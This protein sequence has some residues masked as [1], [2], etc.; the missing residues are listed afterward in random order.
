MFNKVSVF[1]QACGLIE[2]SLK[3]IKPFCNMHERV[4]EH[5]TWVLIA[6]LNIC[7]KSPCIFSFVLFH[8][9]IHSALSIYCC[10]HEQHH[11]EHHHDEH[12]HDEHHH[13]EPHHDEHHYDDHHYHNH[14][15]DK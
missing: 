5:I 10:A 9:S 6:N 13:N 1:V 4:K 7:V 3:Q 14:L 2:T 11:D 12:H 8:F 15:H